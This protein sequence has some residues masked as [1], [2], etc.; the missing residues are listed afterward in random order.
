MK[1]MSKIHQSEE[2]YFEFLQHYTKQHPDFKLSLSQITL[3]K[4][5]FFHAWKGGP[6]IVFDR[7][8]HG[9]IDEFL[10]LEYKLSIEQYIRN[11]TKP[12][13]YR[14]R[15]KAKLYLPDIY[16][17]QVT[18]RIKTLKDRGITLDLASDNETIIE[19]AK[20]YRITTRE[21]LELKKESRGT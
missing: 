1:N 19:T 17:Y 3:T 4:A 6:I 16:Q 10:R 9:L 8:I 5:F 12:R 15:K 7:H 21:V 18:E 2:M 14:A 20:R 11:R 13:R